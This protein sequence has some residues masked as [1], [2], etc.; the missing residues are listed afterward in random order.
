M[1]NNLGRKSG[2]K[3]K[4]NFHL[5][6]LAQA[7][8]VV[9]A[10]MAT[11]SVYADVCGAGTTTI[12]TDVTGDICVLDAGESLVVTASGIVA[13]SGT[14]TASTPTPA[15]G[16]AA[17]GTTVAGSITNAGTIRGFN[18]STS[19]VPTDITLTTA[20]GIA[21]ISTASINGGIT[22]NGGTIEG[23][24]AATNA[25]AGTTGSSDS[26]PTVRAMS[27]T[28]ISI[29][30][31]GTVNGGITNNAGTIA[32]IAEA[33]IHGATASQAGSVK[34]NASAYAFYAY[35]IL[36]DPFATLAG[37]I[38][39]SGTI[40]GQAIAD[41]NVKEAPTNTTIA[42][43][44][45]AYA[46][47]HTAYGIYINGTYNDVGAGFINNGTISGLASASVDV[48][49]MTSLYKIYAEAS[50]AY[51]AY[52]GSNADIAGD[53]TNTGL[54]EGRAIASA[55]ASGINSTTAS[56]ED[57]QSVYADHAY[58]LYLKSADVAG[59]LTNS[60]T[61]AGEASASV[62]ISNFKT[63]D[64]SVYVDGSR[65]YGL[66]LD[67]ADITGG[68]NNTG[69]ISGDVDMTYIADNVFSIDAY[70]SSISADRGYGI[71]ARGSSSTHAIIGSITNDGGT[72]SGTA[73]ASVDVN[74]FTHIDDTV[75]AS[76]SIAY[77]IYNQ[78]V[79]ITGNLDNSGTISALASA[80][81]SL[82]GKDTNANVT[83][84]VSA[85]AS[86]AYGI[87]METSDIGGSLI[88]SGTISG[89]ATADVLLETMDRVEESVSAS[90][91]YAYGVYLNSTPIAGNLTNTG[92]IEGILEA[93]LTARN[94][95]KFSSSASADAR[96]A[97]GLYLNYSDI[98][99]SV[100]NDGGTIAASVVATVDV[101]GIT[102]DGSINA[103]ADRAYGLYMYQSAVGGDLTNS[104]EIS[105]LVEGR[106]IVQGAATASPTISRASADAS[107]AYGL[108]YSD[109]ET[110]TGNFDNSGSI[111]A[112]VDASI[113]LSDLYTVGIDSA[114]AGNQASANYAYGIYLT[115]SAIGGALTNNSGAIISADAMASLA[116]NDVSTAYHGQ[117]VNARY[118]SGIY[119]RNSDTGDLTNNGS[120]TAEVGA[121]ADMTDVLS[122]AI[123]GPEGIVL[124][125]GNA[126]GIDLNN[127]TTIGSLTNGIEAE[128]SA[129]V[130]ATLNMTGVST[131][132][133]NYTTGCCPP[134][135]SA[136]G[137]GLSASQAIG[138]YSS[139]G[140]IDGA[141]TNN[142]TISAAVT[143]DLNMTDVSSVSIDGAEGI[144][145]RAEN[146][147]GIDLR[148]TNIN[149]ALT[150][151]SNESITANVAASIDI[152]GGTQVDGAEGIVVVA[153]GVDGAEGAKG[154]SLY[155]SDVAGALTNDG[156]ISADVTASININGVSSV[157]VST[158][159]A[160]AGS[161]YGVYGYD[162]MIGSSA[163]DHFTNNGGSITASANATVNVENVTAFYRASAQASYA[164]GASLDNSPITG[165]LINSGTISGELIADV[166]LTEKNPSTA[167]GYY[168][169]AN[170]SYAYGILLDNSSDISG[171]LENSG[172]IQ[173][174]ALAKLDVQA[175]V[176]S[177]GYA[178]V[179]DIFGIYLNTSDI[180][181]NLENNDSGTI[182][183]VAVA[184]VNLK[185]AGTGS[186]GTQF[187]ARVRDIAGIKLD[188]SSTITGNINNSGIVKGMAT[189][190]LHGATDGVSL[191][192]VFAGDEVFIRASATGIEIRGQSTIDATG[193]TYGV[194]NSGTILGQATATA[195]VSGFWADVTAE[196]VGLLVSSST[197]SSGI[198]NPGSIKG[199]ATANFDG[200][201][202]AVTA[203]GTGIAIE[204]AAVIAGDI[205]NTG[206]IE[207]I[208]TAENAS[209]GGEMATGI[210]ILIESASIT[211]SIMNTAGGV[212]SGTTHGI[213]ITEAGGSVT[214]VNEG[215]DAMGNRSTISSINFVTDE[216]TDDLNI[217]GL[218]GVT[219]EITGDGGDLTISVDGFTLTDDISGFTDAWIVDLS[220]LDLD[221]NATTITVS[222][223]L[224]FGSQLNLKSTINEL[225]ENG[226]VTL[227]APGTFTEYSAFNLDID[228]SAATLTV[229]DQ[230]TLIDSGALTLTVD[231]PG[232]LTDNNIA[233]DF[234][235]SLVSGDLVVT[236]DSIITDLIILDGE[237]EIAEVDFP[238]DSVT[239]GEGLS[240]ELVQK[241]GTLTT[242]PVILDAGAVFSQSVLVPDGEGGFDE[243]GTGILNASTIT[244]GDGA[245]LTLVNQGSGAIDG[246][247][248]GEGDVVFVGEYDTDSA[249]GATN[250]INS[251]LVK[252]EATLALDQDAD[253]TTVTVGEDI[254]GVLN[255]S[256]GTLTAD[257][258]TINPGG[259]F[260]QSGTGVLNTNN[261]TI[262]I[263][264]GATLTL[265][266]QGT[267]AIDGAGPQ[268]G[269]L[270]FA[271]DY[272]TDAAIGDGNSLA[273]LTVNA[274]VTLTADQNIE[275]AE[276]TI[277]GT[278]NQSAGAL[279]AATLIIDGGGSFTQSGDGELGVG[280][281]SISGT[282][283][284]D[285]DTDLT[286]ATTINSGGLLMVTNGFNHAGNL[287]VSG[288]VD[289]GGESVEVAGTFNLDAGAT[290]ITTIN[291]GE[292]D[293]AGSITIT[294]ETTVSE[295]AIIDVMVSEAA[296]IA[297]GTTYTII[298]GPTDGGGVNAPLTITDD[299]NEF[300]FTASTDGDDLV[301]TTVLALLGEEFLA[302]LSPN[303][304]EALAQLK[305]FFE[306]DPALGDAF[307]GITTAAEFEEAIQSISPDVSRAVV[308]VASYVGRST[309]TNVI[310][311][312]TAM[313]SNGVGFSGV[314]AG[315]HLT[316]VGTWLHGFGTA[317]D[318]D[319]RQGINGFKADTFGMTFGADKLV[320]DNLRLGLAFSI[321]GTDSDTKVSGNRL[322]TD[323]FQGSIYGSYVFG[324]Y[325]L[326]AS[327]TYGKNSYDST[328]FISVGPL[329]RT[330]IANFDGDQVILQGTYGLN[331]AYDDGIYINPF[332][333]F[334][335]A[336]LD[337]DG[338]SES[339][340]G[341]LDLTVDA[342]SYENLE[343][344]VGVSVFKETEMNGARFV[345]EIHASWRHEFLDEIQISNSTYAGGGVSF[346]T[347]GFD[348]AN[349]TLNVGVSATMQ[350]NDNID[351]KFSYD[352][353]T[354][355]NYNS[356]SGLFNIRYNF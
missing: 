27:G 19:T 232:I 48:T 104:G 113:T 274:G 57:Y 255:Q 195:A 103:S 55:S 32:G 318:Q 151:T 324:P 199:S 62:H 264:E 185:Q 266:N 295:E 314:A 179:N 338:Y 46:Y 277:A 260:T 80:S 26:S 286:G 120:I 18:T 16:V 31:L 319:E 10:G 225:G 145:V 14:T 189:A 163:D 17:T 329:S 78:Y 47:A 127:N 181:G 122:V 38:E 348:P 247:N 44:H 183:A 239:I 79:D 98:T 123:D 268:E 302:D 114:S 235:T 34:S 269:A 305:E 141:L 190:T 252:D 7:I 237:E 322:N 164:Y 23:N 321:A 102:Q 84:E 63:V 224:T 167:M 354:K 59:A 180:G 309:V 165:D 12:S 8:T 281:L 81:V 157:G 169:Y 300:D 66:Y 323:N 89:K 112:K 259:T 5:K 240:G 263:A 1:R 350:L 272:D 178:S 25:I 45:T 139:S 345:P 316:G 184:D 337:L 142:G 61:I 280:T 52:F 294:G 72:I 111:T 87:R 246:A 285:N 288:T 149:G 227:V 29:E 352:F 328:R 346:I 267:G 229:G 271:G 171:N 236:V 153:G 152:I 76:A 101:T 310:S 205:M 159:S 312:L 129:A 115:S 218:G 107:Y 334:L 92:L 257:T 198:N 211:G 28:G 217:S 6:P 39:N 125:A 203:Y 99:G 43:F 254:S 172:T 124:S 313:R 86:R 351:M 230:F 74:E 182:S 156:A 49:N 41:V 291:S 335:Y 68:I 146:A 331:Y 330:A 3:T 200:D 177:S 67:N 110:I 170:A 317:I 100:T 138:I 128:I 121:T 210:G 15:V 186:T 298:D 174:N 197:I 278:L 137:I 304:L 35:G 303:A 105:A 356:H 71:Y 116:I 238:F 233:F 144:V 155:S 90:V 82:L 131:V 275:A 216:G 242:G 126:R 56:L 140:T 253:V 4:L 96:R 93:N 36:L 176:A 262:T 22:N 91:D 245:T 166:S 20:V 243:T 188:N 162:S 336:N 341:V 83:T 215:E 326:D 347:E 209:A 77:G 251:I 273:S 276:T 64:F 206:T 154:I 133:L 315:N 118:A 53:I 30:A 342:Q 192:V 54:I 132:E 325:Y 204:N 95:L 287:S 306:A 33:R 51:G 213:Q 11:S 158:L 60:G 290:L 173:A 332:A 223:D 147:I 214:I 187:Y 73:N 134:P 130:T 117:S 355:S 231:Q 270:I 135:S 175:T 70:L 13:F 234:V 339:G 212:I 148:Y 42:Y 65:A 301:L 283:N 219:G 202:G 258:V 201:T 296:V 320:A 191:P 193:T 344:N 292:T 194:D 88:N 226:S 340:A 244:L 207:G 208:A 2:K 160:T 69:T 119:M 289:V 75:A 143:A 282:F 106:V 50:Y 168:A 308:N 293:D 196:A 9:C 228:A 37:G 241:S 58:G 279:G 311:R 307:R 327:F 265:V 249:I 108:Y 333:G 85:D 40:K 221:D 248:A 353:E 161:A 222:N 94:F 24:V 150:N 97:Y 256:A 21:V 297:D 250:A 220:T 299:S 349:D 343:S 261:A 109:A 136:Y 284:K